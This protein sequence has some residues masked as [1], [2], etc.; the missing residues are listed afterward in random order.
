MTQTAPQV[1]IYLDVSCP[2]EKNRLAGLT[3]YSI[4]HR[5]WLLNE[6]GPL[7]IT[8]PVRKAHLSRRCFFL[9]MIKMRYPLVNIQKTM[10]HHHAINIYQWVNPL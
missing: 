4:S 1:V 6:E 8:K 9:D 7:F 2:F 5:Y 3:Y 10:E